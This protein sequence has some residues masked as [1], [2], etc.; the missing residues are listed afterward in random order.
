MSSL[1][2]HLLMRPSN[3][4][5]STGCCGT[6]VLV[7]MYDRRSSARF[8][9]RFLTYSRMQEGLPCPDGDHC[10]YAHDFGELDIHMHLTKGHLEEGHKPTK[11]SMVQLTPVHLDLCC[12]I[13]DQ[14]VLRCCLCSSNSCKLI[15]WRPSLPSLQRLAPTT[16][17]RLNPHFAPHMASV[18]NGRSSDSDSESA[19]SRRSS[20]TGRSQA[21]SSSAAVGS[22]SGAKTSE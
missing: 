3:E 17:T 9:A 4:W 22:K 15:H 8:R 5:A 11:L 12:V 1:C 6:G 13:A 7:T 16:G 21:P 19:V 2:T 10:A 18:Q 14:Q 20:N